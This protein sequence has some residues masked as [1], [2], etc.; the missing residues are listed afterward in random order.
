MIFKEMFGNVIAFSYL[1]RTNYCLEQNGIY[2][3][4]YYYPSSC[5][6]WNRFLLSISSL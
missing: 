5:R 6:F 3:I 1:C 4:Y 2:F